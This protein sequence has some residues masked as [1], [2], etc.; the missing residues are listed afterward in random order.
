MKQ[1]T[2][3]L[4]NRLKEI[5]KKAKQ[6]TLKLM[7]RAKDAPVQ[8][9]KFLGHGVCDSISKSLALPTFT[10]TEIL[11]ESNVLKLIHS[12]NIEP[13]ELRG[14]GI[15]LSKFEVDESNK[16]T[17]TLL[18]LFKK[19]AEKKRKSN[20]GK[21]DAEIMEME[22][23]AEK[24][25]KLEETKVVPKNPLQK[26]MRT[27][28]EAVESPKNTSSVKKPT[29]PVSKS[30]VKKRGRPPKN[31][32][33][34]TR[35]P[36][37]SDISTMFSS[38]KTTKKLPQASKID[39]DVLMELPEDIRAEILNQYKEHEKTLEHV[40]PQKSSIVENEEDDSQDVII[41][42]KPSDCP[43]NNDNRESIKA[44]ERKS[45]EDKR[46]SR[47]PS[48]ENI[49]MR[50]DWRQQLIAWI[51]HDKPNVNDIEIL[52]ESAFEMIG[53]ERINEL[54]VKL[55][56]LFRII[57]DTKSCNWHQ[58]YFRIVRSVQEQFQDI[59]NSKLY[60]EE[61]FDCEFCRI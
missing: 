3:E 40:S 15:Q 33:S 26:W 61:N 57:S 14:I 46:E 39:M 38:M 17:N 22:V 24:K 20:E 11:I 4:I 31:S 27:S 7:I 53:F 42:D 55:K 49:L 52:V 13:C 51:E 19:V 35:K 56:C 43:K 23:Q 32:T 8:T 6:L 41:I 45:L 16:N 21:T 1:L 25:V 60:V 28:N 37:N 47:Q 10:D 36:S 34:F 18:N 5:G 58:V 50:P 30:P 2:V 12:L 54:F 48:P 44:E 59:F 9:M 29:V